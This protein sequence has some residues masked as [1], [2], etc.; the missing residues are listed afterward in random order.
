MN[1]SV[2]KGKKRNLAV[3]LVRNNFRGSN[4]EAKFKV[5][6]NKELSQ[7]ISLRVR[8]NLR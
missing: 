7:N 4:K 2:T 6:S 1:G 3:K 5:V 8:L